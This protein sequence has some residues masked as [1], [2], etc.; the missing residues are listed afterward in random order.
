[1]FKNSAV[2]RACRAQIIPIVSTI[3]AMEENRFGYISAITLSI[4]TPIPV[5][6]EFLDGFGGFGRVPDAV[7]KAVSRM[8]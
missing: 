2:I 3:Q 4:A 5:Q 7:E 1:M 6:D 8:L